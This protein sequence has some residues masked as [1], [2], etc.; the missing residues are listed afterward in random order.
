[1]VTIKPHKLRR[2]D[3]LMKGPLLSFLLGAA[4]ALAILIPFL[5]I[6]KGMFIYIGDYNSQQIPFYTYVQQFIRTGGTWSWATDLGSSVINSY[7]FYNIGSPFLWLTVLFPTSWV[8]FLMVP[9]FMLKFG[10]IAAAANLFLGRYAKTRNMAVIASLLYAFCGFNV[11]NI[12]FNHMLDPVVIF[13]LMLWALDGYMYQRK[14]GWFAIFVGLALLN[15]YFFFI[16]NAVFLLLYFGV[17]LAMREYSIDLKNLGLLVLEA[18][19]GVGIGMVLALPAFYNLMGNPRT[20][21][22][23]SGFGLVMYSNVQQY[24]AILSSVFLPPDPPYLPNL[25]TEGAIKWTSMSAFLPIVSVAGVIAYWRGRKKSPMKIVLGITLFMALVPILNS[26]F[27]AFNASYYARWY[28]MPVLIM[29]FMTMQ[30]LEDESFD[31]VFGAKVTLG[32]TAVFAVFGLLPNEKDGQ[33]VLGVAQYNS[34]LWLTILTA[35][36]GI[37]IF[38]VL[39]RYYRHKVR[40]APLLLSA[41]MGFSVFYSV[42]HIS[43]GKFPQWDNDS[44]YMKEMYYGTKQ[45]TL[46]NDQFYRIDAYNTYDNIGLWMD[47]SC[48]QTFNS[49]VTPSIMEFYPMVGVKRDVSSKPERRFYALRGLLSVKYTVMP[50]A[51]QED[52]EA[53][54]GEA[55]YQGNKGWVFY[56]EEGSFVVYENQNFLPLG[57]TYQNY[58]D[59][60][61]LRMAPESERSLL[62]VRAMGLT[63]E[64]AEQYGYLFSGGAYG[65]LLEETPQDG[66]P[67]NRFDYPAVNYE[68]YVQDIEARRTNASYDV[69]ADASGF[70]SHIVLDKENLVFYAVPYDAGFSATVN[71]EPAEVLKVSGGLMAVQAP[72]GDNEIIFTYQ[73]PGFQFGASVTMLSVSLLCLY[74]VLC[75]RSKQKAGKKAMAEGEPTPALPLPGD[76]E[77]SENAKQHLLLLE[78][79]RR[80]AAERAERR[81]QQAEEEAARLALQEEQAEEETPASDAPPQNNNPEEE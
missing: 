24:F 23:A 8:P 78:E 54:M 16:G 48:L 62:L 64:Q 38:Y 41:V 39:V 49:V 45:L 3:G 63:A 53:A 33:R 14:R 30:T 28:Y 18:L 34:K 26:S 20:S 12:F 44:N 32:L 15:S 50:T 66:S 55:E 74:L 25:F 10:G 21:D 80:R 76:G 46:P 58:V 36:L 2:D 52:F 68:A 19:L 31:L 70:T 1:M 61:N 75:L 5:I 67:T 11:Y 57:F 42:A 35:M 69:Q 51:K 81:R 29:C 4:G 7:S 43:L 65:N 73:T 79:K 37:A 60:D 72:A 17:K 71:G 56:K 59:L 22:F 47:K 9:L 6:D 40:F 27:Y 13:P 77:P